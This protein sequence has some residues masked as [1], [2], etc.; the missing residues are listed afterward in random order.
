MGIDL[1]DVL[2]KAVKELAEQ[3]HLAQVILLGGQQCPEEHVG[4]TQGKGF[5]GLDA[6]ARFYTDVHGLELAYSEELTACRQTGLDEGRCQRGLEKLCHSLKMFL[7]VLIN[8]YFVPTLSVQSRCK[9]TNF[10]VHLQ[11]M[12]KKNI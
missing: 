10:L 12:I 4:L 11:C 7:R 8:R 3:F 6:P 5:S 2:L 1:T 9:D